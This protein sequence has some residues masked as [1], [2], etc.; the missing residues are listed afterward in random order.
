M[1]SAPC[2][3]DDIFDVGIFD[4]RDT[5]TAI[6][7]VSIPA[8]GAWTVLTNNALGVN[9]YKRLPDS[10][11]DVWD[12]V[13]DAFDFTQLSA[14]D[15]V[16]IRIDAEVTTTV[17]DQEFSIKLEMA[18]GTGNVRDVFYVGQQYVKAASTVNVGVTNTININI[19]PDIVSPAQFLCS[20]ASAATV[21]I[22]AFMCKVIK[23]GYVVT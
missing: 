2:G 5:A 18:Q 3:T 17:A 6:T 14:G 21:E 12:D 1:K 10:V 16:D 19:S 23:R 7:P 22:K 13:T 8:G 15:L 11:T 20:S 9:T 4:Y